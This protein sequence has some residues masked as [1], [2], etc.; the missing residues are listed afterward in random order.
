MATACSTLL[1]DLLD[2]LRDPN[3][4][5][6]AT[7]SPPTTASGT[8][9]GY[10]LL[11]VAE[12]FVN[13]AILQYK[14]I[15]SVTF[16]GSYVLYDMLVS[17]PSDYGGKITAINTTSQELDGPVD[18]RALGRANL[19]WLTATGSTYLQWAPIG[20]EFVAVVPAISSSQPTLYI[21]YVALT[22]NE[23]SGNNITLSDDASENITN[24][25]ELLGRIKTRQLT[26]FQQRVQDFAAALK[27]R[28]DLAA[29]GG[30]AD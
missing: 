26:N 29:T 7:N 30:K 24:L 20:N 8:T 10:T 17:G 25:A 2:R 28:I 3:A 12:Q 23:A 21:Y 5:M 11:T 13:L 14:N 9:L 22:P 4:Q 6:L 18:F 27:V 16:S 19:N 15:Y 1:S